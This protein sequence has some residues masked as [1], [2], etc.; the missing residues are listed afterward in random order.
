LCKE[1]TLADYSNNKF[2]ITKLTKSILKL[3]TFKGIE[4]LLKDVREMHR[5]L[6]ELS[7]GEKYAVLMDATNYFSSSHKVRT[8]IASKQLTDTRYATAFVIKSLANRLMAHLFIQFHK[9]AT[10]SRIFDDEASAFKWLKE[11]E[12]MNI[13]KIN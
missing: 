2:E 5:A 10:P 6:M 7:G 9:P 12:E 13:T 1:K 4:L 11:Q 3:K 8:M